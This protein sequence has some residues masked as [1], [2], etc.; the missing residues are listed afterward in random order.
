MSF[1]YA[2]RFSMFSFPGFEPVEMQRDAGQLDRKSFVWVHVYHKTRRDGIGGR[3]CF[4]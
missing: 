1:V 4:E 3:L 2:T